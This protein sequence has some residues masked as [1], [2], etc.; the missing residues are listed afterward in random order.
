MNTA[1]P[2]RKQ[3]NR[4]GVFHFYFPCTLSSVRQS[5]YLFLCRQSSNCSLFIKH[6]KDATC[7]TL[8]TY[9]LLPALLFSG[10]KVILGP[11]LPLLIVINVRGGTKKIGIEYYFFISVYLFSSLW[12]FRSHTIPRTLPKV[13]S[14]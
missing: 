6:R 11:P 3:K 2:R 12:K 9:I 1:H 10:A 8:F 7:R 14:T 5:E 4:I 13:K